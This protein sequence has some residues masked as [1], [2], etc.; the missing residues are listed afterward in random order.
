MMVIA[1]VSIMYLW[2]V[3]YQR[4]RHESNKSGKSRSG[5]TT[6]TSSSAT[7]NRRQKKLRDGGCGMA[8]YDFVWYGMDGGSRVIESRDDDDVS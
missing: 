3:A 2:L 1:R 5:F 8:R 7:T 4:I 6:T